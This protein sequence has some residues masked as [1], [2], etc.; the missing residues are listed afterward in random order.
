MKLQMLLQFAA[1]LQLA[2]AVLNLFLVP[3]LKWREDL[4]RMPLLLREV[5]QVHAWFISITLTIF[6]AMTWRFAFEMAGGADRVCQ[7]LTAGIGIFWAIRAVLQATYY[8]SSH[9][10]GQLGRT[11]AHIGLLIVYGVFATVYLWTAL[12]PE[13]RKPISNASVTEG[14]AHLARIF[15][16]AGRSSSVRSAMFIVTTTPDAQPSS[17]GAAWMRIL[18]LRQCASEPE[19][20]PLLRSLAD[21]AACVAINMALLTELFASPP[22]PLRRVKDPCKV[23]RGRAHS[24]EANSGRHRRTPPIQ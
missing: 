24:V 21:R 8:S 10:R 6:A 20:M 13:M 12:G 4:E 14:R 1:M 11:L 5:F 9:W 15:G 16:G 18:A 23:Q 19:S 2:I 7:W 17:V 3:L 22:P